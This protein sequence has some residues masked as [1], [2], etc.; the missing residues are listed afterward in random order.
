MKFK[1][2]KCGTEF[3]ARLVA[4]CP[5]CGEAMDVQPIHAY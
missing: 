5:N 3:E 4:R 1:C 2:N